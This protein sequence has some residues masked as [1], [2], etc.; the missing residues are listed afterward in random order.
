MSE[1]EQNSNAFLSIIH[2]LA[3]SKSS[4]FKGEFLYSAISGPLDLSN[5]F[6][7]FALPSRPVHFDTNSASPGSILAM[8]Q[9][10]AKTKSLT[11]PALIYTAQSTG[12]SMERTKM[13]NLR[14]GSKGGFEP[15]L[16]WLRVWHSTAELP[17]SKVMFRYHFSWPFFG[18]IE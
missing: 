3:K 16:T 17:R 4:F 7:L 15:G 13:P 12:A 18:R 5:R 10:R 1:C 9:L 8:L 2:F 11:C 6:T 14:N